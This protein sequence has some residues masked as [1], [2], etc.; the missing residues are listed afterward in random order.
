MGSS[1]GGPSATWP[2]FPFLMNE[3]HPTP[4]RRFFG[5][6]QVANVIAGFIGWILAHLVITH[7]PSLK[8]LVRGLF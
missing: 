1:T 5:A 8:E 2:R 3:N 4:S 6:G 7:W